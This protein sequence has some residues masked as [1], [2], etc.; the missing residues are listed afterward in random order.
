MQLEEEF[1]INIPEEDAARINTIA[2]ALRYLALRN[3]KSD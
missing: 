2:E 3:R 1:D